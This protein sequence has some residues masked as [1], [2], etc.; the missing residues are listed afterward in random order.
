ML[1]FLRSW[2]VSA[3]ISSRRNGGFPQS[4]LPWGQCPQ[5]K[6][7]DASG[8]GRYGAQLMLKNAP[9]ETKNSKPLHKKE[10]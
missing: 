5:G 1:H 8:F 2:S 6:H 4:M 7:I 10:L 9:G 3:N